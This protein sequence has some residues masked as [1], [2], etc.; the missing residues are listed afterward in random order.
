M[1][2]WIYEN[3][4]INSVEDF[5]DGV[6]GF[7]YRITNQTK[8]KKYIGKKILSH[9]I[10]RPPLKG[11][12]RKRK[13]IKESNW[14]EYT[15]SNEQLNEDILKGDVIKKEI[16]KLCFNKKQMSYYETKYQFL[17]NVLEDDSYYNSNI[18]GKFF[19]KD[20]DLT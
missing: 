6:I 14:Q 3:K 11:L 17:E 4:K 10:T 5:P 18:L 12:K 20:V 19:R 9:K 8:S 13:I 2:E 15:G 7:V 1:S 16:L